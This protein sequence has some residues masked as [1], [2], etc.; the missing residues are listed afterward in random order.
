MKNPVNSRAFWP[1][2]IY[3]SLCFVG[4]TFEKKSMMIYM[5][6]LP[7]GSLISGFVI[8]FLQMLA[9]TYS[10]Y[11]KIDDYFIDKAEPSKEDIKP[12]ENIAPTYKNSLNLDDLYRLKQYK[13][14]KKYYDQIMV[15]ILLS[16]KYYKVSDILN[17]YIKQK[18][19]SSV[20]FSYMMGSSHQNVSNILL[21]KRK[22]LQNRFLRKL[23]RKFGIPFEIWRKFDA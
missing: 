1:L 20:N 13:H 19:I 22:Y 4:C 3:F 11:I 18:N 5:A 23:E 2:T 7:V 21:K 9:E 8:L 12:Q 15:E 17:E 6:S 16:Q 10:E 14:E